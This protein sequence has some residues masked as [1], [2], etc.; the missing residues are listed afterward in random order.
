MPFA[1]PAIPRKMLPPPTTTH[2]SWPVA[3]AAAISA[4]RPATVSGS[5][6]NWPGPINASPDSFSRIRLNRGRVMEIGYPRVWRMR[7]YGAPAR[8][9]TAVCPWR[10]RTQKGRSR[11]PA[12][13]FLAPIR[14][15]GDRLVFFGACGSRDFRGEI[16]LLLLDAFAQLETDE[17]LERNRR[18]GILAGGGDDVGDRSLVVHDEQLA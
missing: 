9:P 6:P 17:T 8:L 13:P 14:R 5:M 4:A 2:N 16:V 18:T 11:S 3:F 15:S 10:Q 7:F 1:A 12:L